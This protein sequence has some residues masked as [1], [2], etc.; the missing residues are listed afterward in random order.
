MKKFTLTLFVALLIGGQ[1]LL[2][3]NIR[4]TGTVSD[5]SGA[6]LPGVTVVVEGTQQGTTTLANGTYAIN[7]P[8][9]GSLQFSFIG[10]VPVTI[11]VQGRSSINVVL[12]GDTEVIDDVIVVAYGTA[13]KST[14]T[15]AAS[16]VSTVSSMKDLSLMSF[17]N[18][19]QGSAPGIQV[20]VRTGQPGTRPSIRIRG[21][22]SYNASNDPLYVI[23]GIPVTSA[24]FNLAGYG[25]S[26][27]L[28][29]SINPSDIESMTILKDAAAT[30]LYGSR[31]AN[32]VIMIT[33]KKGKAG[34][35]SITFKGSWGFND[36]AMDS[37]PILNGE[38]SH[39]L[40]YE[41]AYN[42]AL[43]AGLT[44]DDAEKYAQDRADQYYPLRDSYSDWEDALTRQAR[45]SSYEVAISGG[46]EKTTFYTS[47]GYR[48][49][50]GVFKNSGM[51]GFNGKISVNH[52]NKG[53]TVSA[54]SLM[55]KMEQDQAPGMRTDGYVA[56]A[57]PYYALK[58]YLRPNIPIYNEDGSFYEGNMFTGS[59]YNLAAEM[60]RET[61]RNKPFRFKNSL[62]VGYEFIEGLTLRE[63]ISFDLNDV[64]GV[65]I[66]PNN[67]KNGSTNKGSTSRSNIK[68]MKFY[69]SLVLNY[70]KL[71]AENHN[72]SALAGWDVDDTRR[73]YLGATGHG[74]AS[75]KLWELDNAATPYSVSSYH[76][77]DRL[78]SFFGSVNYSYKDKYYL[79]G[80]FRRDGSSRL[81]E[82]S[83]WGNFWSVSGS[84]RL[85]EENFL[86]NV[87]WLDNL[88][89]RAS[90]GTTGTLPNSYYSSLATYSFSDISYNGSGGSIP[91]RS[92]NPNLSWEKNQVLDIAVEA[93]FLNRI[94]LEVDFYD[95]QTK[96]LL[97]SV[98][99]SLATGFSTTLM[100]VGGMNNRGVEIT[101][102]VDIFK[103]GFTWHSQLV[104]AHNRNKV[105]S[106]VNGEEFAH[107]DY[108]RAREG[109]SLFSFYMRDYAGIDPGT[110]ESMWYIWETDEKGDYTG[111]KFRTKDPAAATRELVDTADPK[112]TGGWSN[113]LSW[114]GFDLNFLFSFTQGGTSFDGGWALT[115]DGTSNPG[116][117]P[118]SRLQLDRWQ[119]PG[120]QA[121][122]PKRMWGGGH[123]NYT[124]TRWLHS[125]DHIRLKTLTF[126]YTVPR[127]LTEKAGVKGLRA[128]IAGNNLL[129]WAAYDEYD[130]EV[131]PS[132]VVDWSIPAMKSITFGVEIRF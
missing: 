22:G 12:Q 123:G 67:S 97:L 125:T 35:L 87:H 77:D 96:D 93:R 30:S 25:G 31:G 41:G 24:D 33:T 39:Y 131:Q 65:S 102:G 36:F 14:F 71:I 38:E 130:P 1:A 82:D 99:L 81:G 43:F 28:M 113:T 49:D 103:G 50:L 69:S 53:W 132:G 20:G 79:S 86:R 94:N 21:T 124:S 75:T 83:R 15:G 9:N 59:Y 68:D 80:T 18:A 17:E 56:Y 63:T 42:Q 64:T 61:S 27:S 100:N 32:G 55:S 37:R 92:A 121:Q 13:K 84:W 76:N 7:A 108:F 89:I 95:R 110:G 26:T 4:V 98:P 111:N 74:F 2:A 126:G 78:V 45:N 117:G 129:T 58:T 54:E 91:S 23:D 57:N 52:Q 47:F 10:M 70:N 73:E 62:S 60:G 40:A 51:S 119:K 107:S 116:I 29:T 112:W 5:E 122:F 11:P 16:N 3:Q 19:L 88:R 44:G 6:P 90:Y 48:E 120:D 128:Y 8:A 101:L 127:K 114:K 85:K 46:N 106:L 115:S 104:A 118:I 109:H 34:D 72:I 66:Y 105:T